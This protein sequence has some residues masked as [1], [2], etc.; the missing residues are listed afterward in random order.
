M[1]FIGILAKFHEFTNSSNETLG[2]HFNHYFSLKE[3]DPY[4]HYAACWFPLRI[5]INSYIRSCSMSGCTSSLYVPALF[6]LS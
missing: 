1:G 6:I 2:I 5:L 3:I 4:G